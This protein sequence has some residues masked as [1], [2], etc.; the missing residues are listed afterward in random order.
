MGKYNG[1]NRNVTLGLWVRD[2]LGLGWVPRWLVYRVS[3]PIDGRGQ[4]FERNVGNPS[5]VAS[6][7]YRVIIRRLEAHDQTSSR[8]TSSSRKR[9]VK[10]GCF[11]KETGFEGLGCL[12]LRFKER[13]VDGGSGV[14]WLTVTQGIG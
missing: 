12:G 2:S 8:F 11:A 9:G 4:W 6:D 13:G 7:S 5:S 10:R 3:R 14:D 1:G